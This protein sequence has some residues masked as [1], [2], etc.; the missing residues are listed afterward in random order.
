MTRA[1][2]LVALL[3][4]PAAH[5]ASGAGLAVLP[6]PEHAS[7]TAAVRTELR[8]LGYDVQDAAET[9]RVINDAR[10]LGA[11]C[12]V[13]VRECALELG[14]VLGARMVVSGLIVAGQLELRGFDVVGEIALGQAQARLDREDV[15]V[16]RL[17]V[18][19]LVRP[20]LEV[21]TLVVD[22]DVAGAT[23]T[24]DGKRV[25]ETP[26]SPQTFSTGAHEVYVAHVDHDSQTHTVVV[27]FAQTASIEVKLRAGSTTPPAKRA[28]RG[29]EEDFVTVAVLDVIGLGGD[30]RAG[31]TAVIVEWLQRKDGVVV[32][33]PAEI[34]ARAGAGGMA[35]LNACT[36]DDCRALQVTE[37][38]TVDEV[39]IAEVVRAGTAG[40]KAKKA[41]A[42]RLRRVAEPGV[43]GAIE[44]PL[45]DESVSVVVPDALG[46]IYPGFADRPGLEPMSV[47]AEKPVSP[48]LI[49]AGVSAGIGIVGLAAGI[50]GAAIPPDPLQ[51][52][53]NAIAASLLWG[54][55]GVCVAGGCATVVLAAVGLLPAERPQP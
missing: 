41:R 31:I 30:E 26:L 35:A 50:T 46:E 43:I 3:C 55:F 51:P 45:R 10:A 20:E 1:I 17:A 21:G 53:R 8:A 38:V 5:A 12:D 4:A 36:S 25:G 9:E 54:G 23:V 22:C 16:A 39:L 13:T 14:G 32:V 19:R 24:V 11:A 2:L 18:I 48:A 7:L 49:G 6:I 15:F 33:T 28:P 27:E 29:D 40:A 47:V 34:A 42:V 52:E 37:A 44:R